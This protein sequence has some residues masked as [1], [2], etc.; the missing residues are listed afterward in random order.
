MVVQISDTN[1]AVVLQRVEEYLKTGKITKAI[2]SDVCKI[3]KLENFFDKTFLTI[4]IPSLGKI[5]KEGER[6]IVAGIRKS[7]NGHVFYVIKKD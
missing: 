7:G 5:M 4:S 3:P 2:A 6:G 1:C